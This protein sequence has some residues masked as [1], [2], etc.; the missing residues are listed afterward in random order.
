MRKTFVHLEVASKGEGDVPVAPFL[1]LFR[2]RPCRLG[3]S[4]SVQLCAGGCQRTEECVL[5]GVSIVWRLC[6]GVSGLKSVWRL[7]AGVSAD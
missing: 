4:G 2:R 6:W 1:L 7:C 3:V 5:G